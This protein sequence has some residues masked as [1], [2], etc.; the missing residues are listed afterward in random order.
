M[1][2]FSRLLIVLDKRYLK[3]KKLCSTLKKLN[4]EKNN[5]M[6]TEKIIQMIISFEHNHLQKNIEAKLTNIGKK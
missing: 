1:S 2:N 4:K 5:P 3:S 6:Q